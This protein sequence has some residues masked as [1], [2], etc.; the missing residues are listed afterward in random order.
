MSSSETPRFATPHAQVRRRHVLY[1]EGYD[2]QGAEG[3]YRLFQ[4]AR[5][6][7]RN[8]WPIR[9]DLGPLM[10][11]SEEIACWHVAAHAPN[12]SVV[13]RYEFLRQEQFIRADMAEPMRRHIVRSLAWI[14]D[15]IVSGALF[16]ILRASWR[17]G[18]ALLYFEL[19]LL[20]WLALP[21]ALGVEIGLVL[22]RALPGLI[23]VPIAAAVLAAVVLFLLSRPLADRLQVVQITNHWPRLRKYARGEPTWFDQTI[24]TGAQRLIEIARASEADEIVV[25]GHSGGGVMAP[26]VVARAFELDGE[27]GRRGPKLVLLTLGSIMPAVGLHP[28]AKRMRAAIARL[29]SECSLTWVDCQSRKDIL[30]FWDFDPVTG[31]GIDPGARRCNPLIWTVRF[32]DMV[33]PQYYRRFR[34]SFFRLHYQFI[35]TGDR[36][37]PYDYLMLVVGPFAVAE[38]ARRPHELLAAFSDDGALEP[39]RPGAVLRG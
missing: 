32:K 25:I 18:L 9:L 27:L 28:A 4:G 2:P 7:F 34:V 19:L 22:E 16:R 3:Y 17:F 8:I 23:A 11:A 38:W 20:A 30:N 35:M 14:A 12:W 37:A 29:S 31:I 10:L 36:R 13:T 15:D 6:R 1:V 39:A 26:A 5:R 33:S 21:V 24:E